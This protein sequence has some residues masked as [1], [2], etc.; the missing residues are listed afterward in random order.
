MSQKR[1][2]SAA[3]ASVRTSSDAPSAET[4][5]PKT[6]PAAPERVPKRSRRGVD[7]EDVND[8]HSSSHA[9]QNGLQVK[10]YTARIPDEIFDRLFKD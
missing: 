4:S 5:A 7:P 10:D 6:V 2:S 8:W 3:T 1:E 9:L